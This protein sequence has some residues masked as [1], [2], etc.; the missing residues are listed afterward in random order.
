V[1]NP[2]A[3]LFQAPAA[4]LRTIAVA[5]DLGRLFGTANMLTGQKLREL[6]HRNWAVAPG[7]WA[8]PAGW[9]PRH[10]LADGFAQTVAWYRRAGWL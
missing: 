3:R 7:E 6:R 5:G 1:G 10:S 9:A 4:L 2:G 8:Q